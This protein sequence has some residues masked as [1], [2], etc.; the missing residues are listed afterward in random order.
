M[1]QAPA[2]VRLGERLK[3]DFSVP[4]GFSSVLSLGGEVNV[5]TTW[6][7]K[8][9]SRLRAE[10]PETALRI[11]VDIPGDL[12]D[13]FA[14]GTIDVALMH[15]PPARSGLKADLLMEDR[16][17]LYT[18]DPSIRSIYDPR[19]VYVNWGE[20][21]I[22]SF[23][24]S[25]PLFEGAA[26]SFDYGPLAARYVTGNG[27]AAYGRQSVAPPFLE[28]G[29]ISAVEGAVTFAYP[30]YIVRPSDTPNPTLDQAI[31]VLRKIVKENSTGAG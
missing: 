31:K 29:Q 11:K 28:T 19:F 27:G 2:F 17:I 23:K 7:N 20:A 18:T 15:T 16:L 10:M 5:A 13:C 6:M 25:Y 26:V 30:M 9:A 3:G 14:E 24:H 21:F 1:R 12:I 22:A 8:W 4:E